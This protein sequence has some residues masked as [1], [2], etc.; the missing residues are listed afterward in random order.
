L[1]PKKVS[2]RS[3]EEGQTLVQFADEYREFSRSVFSKGTQ[4]LHGLALKE[5]VVIAGNIPLNQITQFTSIFLK[6]GLFNESARQQLM[7]DCQKMKAV[8]QYGR[9]VEADSI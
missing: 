9:L 6:Q 7:N 1:I 8:P 4:Y 2:L 3:K 5:L